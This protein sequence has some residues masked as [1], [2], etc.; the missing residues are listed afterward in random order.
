MKN[1]NG[2]LREIKSLIPNA[3]QIDIE[4]ICRERGVSFSAVN[5]IRLSAIA[6]SSVTV[7][8]KNIPL[9]VRLGFDD[10]HNVLKS[11]CDMAIFAH[12]DD[13]SNGFV[14]LKGGGRVGVCGHAKYEGG[15]LV[16]ISSVSALVFR[17]P[18]GRCDFAAKLY[19][20][21]R[22][23]GYSGMLICSRAGVGKTTAIRALAAMAGDVRVAKKVVVVDERCE[24]DPEAY[25]DCTVDI[26]RG[27][28]RRRGIEIAI[29]TMS[30]D[31]LIVD[32]IGNDEDSE[33]LMLSLGAG[34]SVLATAHGDD[35]LSIYKKPAVKRLIDGGLFRSYAIVSVGT[36]GR[37]LS[38]GEMSDLFKNDT[39]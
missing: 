34:V 38:V 6:L 22:E 16:G 18:V 35:I 31:I 2:V 11:C 29:R 13:I 36:S 30:A 28:K 15:Q 39:V 10:V 21:W 4:R 23:R 12:R 19:S 14:S 9:T 8:G 7:R 33:A 1:Y 27:Y 32:E 37:S 5:E 26:L 25:R 17:I 20:Y 3:V 24:F